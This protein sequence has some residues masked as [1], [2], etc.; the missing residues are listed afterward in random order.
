MQSIPHSGMGRLSIP[1]ARLSSWSSALSVVPARLTLLY[2]Q[3]LHGDELG[4][5]SESAQ[6]GPGLLVRLG[7]TPASASAILES[8]DLLP[9]FPFSLIKSVHFIC[10][11]FISL[12]SVYKSAR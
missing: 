4:S 12:P 3:D 9:D 8:S 6:S 7:R 5:P 2:S 11:I 1:E 10:L